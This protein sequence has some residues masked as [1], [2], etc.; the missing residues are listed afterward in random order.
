MEEQAGVRPTE[1]AEKLSTW[2]AAVVLICRPD[3][4][5]QGLY[6]KTA[7]KPAKWVRKPFG[8]SC[9]HSQAV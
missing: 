9:D 4:S 8:V 2:D 5:A 6:A 3:H 1:F 7:P